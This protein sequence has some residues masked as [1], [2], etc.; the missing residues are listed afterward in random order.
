M[1]IA[2]CFII[3]YEH[4]VHKEAIWREWI[5]SNKDLINV[6][7]YYSDLS[8]IRSPWVMQHTIPPS[9][10][11]P[12]SY[13]HV[14]PAYLS[15]MQFAL[16]N[17]ARNQWFCLL[18]DSCCPI[19]SP[20]RFRHLFYQHYSKS[21]IN[22]RKAWWNLDLQKRANLHKLPE[23]MRLANDPWFV[24]K[25]EHVKQCI[26]FIQVQPNIAQ[27]VTSGGLAN[28]S[29][30][31]IVLYSYSQL[32]KVIASATHMTDWL[33]RSSST[34]PHMFR[35]ADESDIHFIEKN[36]L[37]N[38]YAMFIRKIHPEFPDEVLRKYIYEY[39]KER[40]DQLVLHDPFAKQRFYYYLSEVFFTIIYFLPIFVAVWWYCSL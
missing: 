35:L 15:V 14:V 8:K 24:L 26:Q 28:E 17:D 20:K 23:E 5:E 38:E 3:N 30:F 18:T 27:I 1:K 25:R 21:I 29:L 9:C 11:V 10:I 32:D 36:L 13:F 6:Y 12:T 33:R 16:N 7:F 34:S 19:I 31:A 2:L 4:F 39:S 40:D 22:W 37:K